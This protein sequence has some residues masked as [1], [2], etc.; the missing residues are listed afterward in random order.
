MAYELLIVSAFAMYFVVYA[1]ISA[2]AS[3]RCFA[4]H[5]LELSIKRTSM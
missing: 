1:T 5:C 2:Y 3:V 4:V